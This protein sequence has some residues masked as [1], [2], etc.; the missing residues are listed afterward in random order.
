MK[1]SSGP[2]LNLQVENQQLREENAKLKQ[3]LASKPAQITAPKKG[4]LP[5]LKK[6]EDSTG[7]RVHY[8]MLDVGHKG[9]C[10]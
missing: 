8:C 5:C 6:I 4:N 1:F 2:N 10:K 3:D 9:E 7:I